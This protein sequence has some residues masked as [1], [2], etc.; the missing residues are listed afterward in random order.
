VL[1]GQIAD[2]QRSNVMHAEF[3]EEGYESEES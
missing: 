3:E 1:N 2:M